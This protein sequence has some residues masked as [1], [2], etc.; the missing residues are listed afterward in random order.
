MDDR[1][2]Q[3]SSSAADPALVA[4]VMHELKQP[5]MGIRCGLEV[6]ARSLG[7]VVTQ[8][9][10]WGA[11]LELV[12]QLGEVLEGWQC[13]VDPRV[14]VAAPFA[15][16]PVVQHAVSLL[17][18]RLR[19]LGERFAVVLQPP[20]PP[21]HGSRRALLHALLNLL[22]N[23][24][25]AVRERGGDR[26]IEVRVRAAADGRALEISV[27]DDGAGIPPATAVR[28]FEAGATGKPAGEGSGL[29]LHLGRALLE[30]SGGALR[31][32][33]GVEPGRAPWA[34]TE[35]VIELPTPEVA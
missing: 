35:F 7:D 4:G 1:D 26:R 28:L 29:G 9:E 19:P 15:V 33:A 18:F 3:L 31:L 34:V 6:L 11:L 2:R 24:L 14:E 5:L 23:A 25:D 20:L 12:G 22:S 10:E 21:A 32:A 8:H 16:E 30:R 27:S 17:R 13:L